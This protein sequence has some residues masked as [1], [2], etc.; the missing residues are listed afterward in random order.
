MAAKTLFEKLWD[1]HVVREN[2]DGRAL[3]FTVAVAALTTLV[4]GLAPAWRATRQQL[5]A[6]LG[7][8]G[9]TEALLV[10]TAVVAVFV[11]FAAALAWADRQTSASRPDSGAKRRAS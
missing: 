6:V 11:A 7:A 9:P 8:A 2:A 1:Q 3:L 10:M 4:F 5:N